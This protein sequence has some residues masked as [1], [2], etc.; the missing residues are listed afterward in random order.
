MRYP[1]LDHRWFILHS[2]TRRARFAHERRWEC[3]QR[4]GLLGALP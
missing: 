1:T 4:L 2:R 3:L